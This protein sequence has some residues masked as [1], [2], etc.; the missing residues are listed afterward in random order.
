MPPQSS[1]PVFQNTRFRN[2]TRR[3]VAGAT[4]GAIIA[5]VT[6]EIGEA[7]A[8]IAPPA[9]PATVFVGV[10]EALGGARFVET[11]N[12]FAATAAGRK[13]NPMAFAG[14][15]AAEPCAAALPQLSDLATF[16]LAFYLAAQ[17]APAPSIG[18]CCLTADLARNYPELILRFQPGWRYI[19]L[20]WPVHK[21]VAGG[22]TPDALRALP[23]SGGIGLRIAPAGYGVSIEELLPAPF[24]LE[25]S[26]RAG[27]QLAA[28]AL[29]ATSLDPAF[30]PYA[31][32]AA[33]A[34]DG[35]IID[36][37]AVARS[38]VADCPKP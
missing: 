15:L 36:A 16:D 22:A 10:T 8:P 4:P 38:A 28:A 21:L 32:V 11:W 17:P 2:C 23:M 19:A 13:P 37:I 24:A 33:L 6:G 9:E 7:C 14:F 20:S 27:R 18:A 35:A 5:A 12:R 29:A 25:S 30:D 1:D 34:D 3:A 31:A 26:L